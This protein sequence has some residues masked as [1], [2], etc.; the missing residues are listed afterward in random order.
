MATEDNL[1]DRARVS[2]GDPPPLRP[3]E[4]LLPLSINYTGIYIYIRLLHGM[5]P[6]AAARSSATA[7]LLQNIAP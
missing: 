4:P 7:T 1:V 5:I 3:N 6:N 2:V